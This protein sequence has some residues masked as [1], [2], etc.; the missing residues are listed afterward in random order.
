MSVQDDKKTKG[1]GTSRDSCPTSLGR[2]ALL[3][4]GVVAMPAILT[5][6]SGAAL[7]RSS[8]LI[9][10]SSPGT[11]DRLGRTLCLDTNSV[12]RAGRHRGV[13]DMGEDPP[14]AVVNILRDQEYFVRNPDRGDGDWDDHE[15]DWDDR[16]SDLDHDYFGDHERGYTSY[17][18]PY[19]CKEGGNYWVKRRYGYRYRSVKLPGNGVVLSSGAVMSMADDITGK[20]I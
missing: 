19:V 16:D 12:V 9:S 4:R 18:A 5:L 2:R 10:A 7:A 15:G 6:Q 8:N 13:Y 3:R 11:T 20:L 14:H 1:S 17:N